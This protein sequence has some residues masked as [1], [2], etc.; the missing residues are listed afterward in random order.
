MIF[1]ILTL[2]RLSFIWLFDMS[3]Q[4]FLYAGRARD[5]C[6]LQMRVNLQI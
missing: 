3:K 1:P 4:L 2:R 5:S 6:F